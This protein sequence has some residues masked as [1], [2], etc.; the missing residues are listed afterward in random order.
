MSDSISRDSSIGCRDSNRRFL[1]VPDDEVAACRVLRAVA[2]SDTSRQ[3][4]GLAVRQPSPAAGTAAC[5]GDIR[6]TLGGPVETYAAGQ[7]IVDKPGVIEDSRFGWVRDGDD[8]T[9][10]VQLRQS[11]HVVGRRVDVIHHFGDDTVTPSTTRRPVRP[12]LLPLA[13]GDLLAAWYDA[14]WSPI[15]GRQATALTVAAAT[16]MVAK[17]DHTTDTWAT[18]AYGPIPSDATYSLFIAGL[19]V[20]QF[21]DTGEILMFTPVNN[22][23]TPGSADHRRLFVFVSTDDGATW[24]ERGRKHFDGPV[25]DVVLDASGDGIMDDTSPIVGCAAELLPSGRIVLLMLTEDYTWSLTSDDRGST[26]TATKVKTH[27]SD[28]KYAGHGAGST[29][30]RNGVAA[31]HVARRGTEDTAYPTWL[32]LTAN[33][34]DFSDEIQTSSNLTTVDSTICLS[35]DGWPHIYGTAHNFTDPADLTVTTKDW[36]WGRRLK[37]RD[38]QI[39]STSQDLLPYPLAGGGFTRLNFAFHTHEPHEAAGEYWIAESPAITPCVIYHGF[40]GIDAVHYRGQVVMLAAMQHDHWVVEDQAEQ[41]E[42]IESGLVVFRLNHWQPLRERLGQSHPSDDAWTPSYPAGGYIYNRTWDCYG[43]PDLWNFTENGAGTTTMVY[44]GAEGG[45]MEIE[46]PAAR[47]YTDSSLPAAHTYREGM[48]RCVVQAKEGGSASSDAIAVRLFLA[49]GSTSAGCINVRLERK[50]EGTYV[51]LINYASGALVA[52][53]LFPNDQWIEIVAAMQHKGSAFGAKVY[54][55]NYPRDTDPDWDEPYTFVGEIS[56]GTTTTSGDGIVFGNFTTDAAK[57]WWKSVHV[58]RANESGKA[59]LG[60]WASTTAEQDAWSDTTSLGTGEPRLDSGIGNIMRSP[61]TSSSPPQFLTRGLSVAWRGEATTR[62]RYDFAAD[63]DFA[64]ENLL[65]APVLREWRSVDTGSQIE[66]VLDADPNA[67]GRTFRPDAIALLGRNFPEFMLQWSDTDGTWSTD[68]A[69]RFGYF[70]DAH[71][72]NRFS[73]LW[74]MNP[75]KPPTGWS[76][77]INGRR[78]TVFSPGETPQDA[79]PWRPHQ[80]RSL[81]TGPR[82]YVAFKNAN[83]GVTYVYRVEDNTED[84][85]TLATAPT[86]TDMATYTSDPPGWYFNAKF[87]IFSDRL[88]STL[89]HRYPETYDPGDGEL[90]N[91]HVLGY[92]YLR[93][94]IP[95]CTHRDPDEAFMRCGLIF[96]GR[97]VDLS[98]PAVQWGWQR[99]ESSGQTVDYDDG[100]IGRARRRHS[101]RREVRVDYSYLPSPQEMAAA[102]LSPEDAM[103]AGVRSWQHWLDAVR[104][105]EVDGTPAVLVWEGDR[106]TAS[107]SD[108]GSIYPGACASDPKDLMLCRVTK[109][110]TVEHVAYEY[111][112]QNLSSGL[113]AVPRPGAVIR[114]I[115]FSEEF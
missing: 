53:A 71:A 5:A 100:G 72:P 102:S 40:V 52:S 113:V 64:A 82:F 62:G 17:L 1:I 57:S 21:S 105:L 74:G 10:D 38:A 54:A 87:S 6:P 108:A 107:S 76:Y 66:I 98:S 16:I 4:A 85:L 47:T 12:K 75:V 97:A 58:S 13:S 29:L 59:D 37:S 79:R 73:H 89:E 70:F 15:F 69:C 22:A 101:P 2:T 99:E 114:G 51:H 91:S 11:P 55:R 32:L 31:F 34:V 28:F 36:L 30:L 23:N 90:P 25:P 84:T 81:R 67:E 104:R 110:G 86:L 93:L 20:I 88:A 19:D 42:L 44:G 9:T 103:P 39:S 45:Y 14:D 109:P 33:G 48:L 8:P 94:L 83:S 65:A 3:E 111:A 61:T 78:L 50:S 43:K 24:I 7:L 68:D 18:P 96:L 35:P 77:S 95:A 115:V 106:F 80:F 46:S 41:P 63:Y 112:L 26:W 92:R 56:T 49:Y 60:G 27:E